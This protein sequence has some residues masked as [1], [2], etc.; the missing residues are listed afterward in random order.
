M[1]AS[2]FSLEIANIRSR[3][4][5]N[6]AKQQNKNKNTFFVCMCVSFERMWHAVIAERYDIS[7]LASGG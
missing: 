4:A 6:A 3:H 2:A 5:A 7:A 1:V